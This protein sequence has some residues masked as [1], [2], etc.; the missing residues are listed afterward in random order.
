[1]SWSLPWW[2]WLM[3]SPHAM[4]DSLVIS[5]KSREILSNLIKVWFGS[6]LNLEKLITILRPIT[7]FDVPY[8]IVAKAMALRIKQILPTVIQPEQTRF[9]TV[10]SSSTTLSLFEKGWN[11]QDAWFGCLIHQVRFWEGLS[12]S[13]T[14]FHFSYMFKT[15]GLGKYFKWV[16]ETLFSKSS[17]YLSINQDKCKEIGLF[18]SIW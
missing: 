10:I 15:L 3:I 9:V 6:I 16:V 18:I 8:K 12:Q 17:T 11:V 1:M 5:T 14:T 2:K 4:R 7:L 13:A